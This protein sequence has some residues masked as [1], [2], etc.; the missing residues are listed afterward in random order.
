LLLSPRF[1]DCFLR[2]FLLSS[3]RFFDSFTIAPRRRRRLPIFSAT[4]SELNVIISL[5]FRPAFHLLR[6]IERQS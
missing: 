1:D 3:F 5:H 6:H 4:F 2:R